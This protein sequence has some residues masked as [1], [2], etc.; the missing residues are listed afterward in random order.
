MQKFK[1]VEELINQLKPNDPVYCIRKKSI[2][3]A[4]RFFKN[5]FPGDVL[6]AVKTN[7]NPLVLKTIFE[8]GIDIGLTNTIIINNAHLLGLSQLHQLRGRV[9]RSSYQAFAWFL[10]P[11][12]NITENAIKRLKAITKHNM[13]GVGYNIS[14]EDLTIRGSG[15]LFGYKQSGVGGVGFDYYSKLLALAVKGLNINSAVDCIVDL[16]N[17]PIS[18]K[19]INDGNSRAFYYKTIFSAENKFDL[20]KIKEEIVLLYGFCSP[21]IDHLLLCREISLAAQ[22]KH[23]KSIIKTKQTTTISFNLDVVEKHVLYLIEYIKDFFDKK[24]IAFHFISS[25]KSLIFKFQHTA[26]N[27]YILLMSFINNLSFIK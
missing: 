11:K 27:D 3:L 12:K 2:Q 26:K 18:P 9:G 6:Y 7:P 10:V 22:T 17:K 25:Q 14:L 4:S 21:E 23:I 1:T 16:N 20:K 5:K 15:S 19:F 8:S 13:L 24:S